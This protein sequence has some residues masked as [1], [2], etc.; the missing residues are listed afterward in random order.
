[1]N[2]LVAPWEA[3]EQLLERV[4]REGRASLANRAGISFFV[5]R[6]ALSG[7]SVLTVCEEDRMDALAD[8][9]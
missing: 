3:F 4:I 8:E 6:A 9:F 1:M 7:R 2:D 5:L